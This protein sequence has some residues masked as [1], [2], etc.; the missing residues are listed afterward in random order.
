[1]RTKRPGREPNYRGA[2]CKKK[3]KSTFC[4]TWRGKELKMFYCESFWWMMRV[5]MLF[6]GRDEPAIKEQSRKTFIT[7]LANTRFA[8][9]QLDCIL[10]A[11]AAEWDLSFSS[12]QLETIYKLCLAFGNVDGNIFCYSKCPC[13]ILRWV[14]QSHI[15]WDAFI[16][17]WHLIVHSN[18][19]SPNLNLYT[20]E[21]HCVRL[22]SGLH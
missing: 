1:M 22:F 9:W 18:S 14:L 10:R 21:W 6:M 15:M 4:V 3:W 16:K 20:Q 11:G 12:T 7:A 8:V 5:E 19:K 13:S 2:A 17:M